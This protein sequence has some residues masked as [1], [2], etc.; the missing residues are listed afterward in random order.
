[1]AGG[2]RA[3]EDL[4]AFWL[5]ETMSRATQPGAMTTPEAA[6]HITKHVAFEAGYFGRGISVEP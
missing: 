3:I 2:Q 4:L 5:L 1:M 6:R